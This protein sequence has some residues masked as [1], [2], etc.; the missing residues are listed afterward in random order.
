MRRRRRREAVQEVP[1]IDPVC[2][3]HVRGE[4]RV[5]YWDGEGELQREH[6]ELVGELHA[7]G[8]RDVGRHDPHLVHARLCE[9]A[10]REDVTLQQHLGLEPVDEQVD[11]G[12]IT[13]QGVDDERPA[14]R[15]PPGAELAV[16]LRVI[17]GGEVDEGD[18]LRAVVEPLEEGDLEHD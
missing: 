8:Q 5:E 2:H 16:G 6:E 10:A 18:A 15:V 4:E 13:Y 14:R 3:P 17:G 9:R 7:H 12:E 1:P 11:D